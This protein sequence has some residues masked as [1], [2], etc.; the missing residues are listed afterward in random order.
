MVAV[1][2]KEI[3]FDDKEGIVKFAFRIGE[4]GDLPEIELYDDEAYEIAD[5]INRFR[6]TQLAA[7]AA[8]LVSLF[9][10]RR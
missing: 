3:R 8:K 1:R 7:D 9:R 4:D 6:L 10:K 5:F 2:Y